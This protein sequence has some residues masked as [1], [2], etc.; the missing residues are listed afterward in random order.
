MCLE[1]ETWLVQPV[2]FAGSLRPWPGRRQHGCGTSSTC[3]P[4]RE[5]FRLDWI[6]SGA[7][8]DL[9]QRRPGCAWRQGDSHRVTEPGWQ[10]PVA[11]W[12]EP[13]ADPRWRCLASG[14][15]NKGENKTLLLKRFSSTS[16]CLHAL[17]YCFHA[18]LWVQMY[19]EIID[20]VRFLWSLITWEWMR[21]QCTSMCSK[22]VIITLGSL[23]LLVSGNLNG[24]SKS[25]W[26]RHNDSLS[27]SQFLSL[28]TCLFVRLSV[29]PH[30]LAPLSLAAPLTCLRVWC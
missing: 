22:T 29:L 26:H 9:R 17:K 23:L 11:R 5:H 4:D 6:V 8:H 24:L 1:F 25:H 14:R 13:H 20:V 18:R 28:S 27:L 30:T 3:Q 7:D 2:C 12:W 15:G 21:L 10:H 19:L 16:A